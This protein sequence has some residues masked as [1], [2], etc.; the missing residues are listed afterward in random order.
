MVKKLYAAVD[1][2]LHP[3][4][5]R[6]VLAHMIHMIETGRVL[7]DGPPSVVTRYRLAA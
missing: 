4:A 1:P 5:A 3:A 2:R 6:S 7:S